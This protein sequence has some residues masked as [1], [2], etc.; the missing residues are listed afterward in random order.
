MTPRFQRALAL[1]AALAFMA[2]PRGAA[3]QPPKPP[4]QAPPQPEQDPRARIRTVTELVLVP[5]TVKDHTGATVPDLGKKDFRI[6]EDNVEQKIA[7]F[8][9]EPFPLSVVVLLDDDLPT[10]T[11]AFV[12]ASA[13]SLTGGLAPLDEAAVILFEQFP[14]TVIEFTADSDKLHERLKRLDLKHHAPGQ[15]SAAMTSPPRLNTAPIETGVPQASRIPSAGSKS[16]DDAVFAA[17]EL[18]RERGR[19]RRKIILIVSDGRNSH[20]NTAKYE[21]VLRVLLSA[22]I[23]VYGIGVSEAVLNRGTS[24]IARYA[25]STGGDA[26]YAPSRGDLENLYSRVLEQARNQYTLAYSPAGTDRTLEY[27]SIE[28]RAERRGL[29]LLTRDGYFSLVAKK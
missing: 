25:H 9:S 12:D 10:R 21:D 8:S 2:G 22:D 14:R 19:E 15:G 29:D 26:Y 11:A 4:A 27:H 3:Q 16:L 13:G 28:V 18:L 1:L 6:F 17:G 5:V 24:A 20:H 23:S 7:V